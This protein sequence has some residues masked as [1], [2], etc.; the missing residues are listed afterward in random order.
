MGGSVKVESKLG[1]GT[2]FVFNIKTNCIV[3]PIKIK[4]DFL[5]LINQ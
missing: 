1:V 2:S 3:M 4:Q 5:N